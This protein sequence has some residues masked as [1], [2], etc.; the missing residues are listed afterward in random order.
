MTL[1]LRDIYSDRPKKLYHDKVQSICNTCVT[2][3]M[4]F[5]VK[6]ILFKYKRFKDERFRY[7]NTGS[8]HLNHF[9]SE[10]YCAQSDLLTFISLISG[11]KRDIFV[12]RVDSFRD[13]VNLISFFLLPYSH[14][15]RNSTV[16]PPSCGHH[17]QLC[18]ASTHIM[19]ST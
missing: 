15:Y 18:Y 12:I 16:S 9:S 1:L 8:S 5:T 4:S 19:T 7:K 2:C 3:V 17:S 11:T 6:I 10:I 14:R 13:A